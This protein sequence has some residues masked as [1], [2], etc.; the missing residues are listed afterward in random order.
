MGGSGRPPNP[1]A[2]GAP[3]PSRGAPRQR[4]SFTGSEMERRRALASAVPA[5]AD[6]LLARCPGHVYREAMAVLE[7]ALLSPALA[8]TG[9][10]Q[11][12]AAR[13]PGLNRN[14]LRKR[15]RELGLL[16]KEMGPPMPSGESAAA[17]LPVK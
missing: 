2:L 1:P 16:P 4:D 14:T 3:R 7:E 17:D 5:L 9:G 11:L 6:Q 15:C 8:L 10:N 12:R 13:L